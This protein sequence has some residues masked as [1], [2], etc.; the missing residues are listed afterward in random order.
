MSINIRMLQANHGDCFFISHVGGDKVFNIMIDG[1]TKTTFSS[2]IRQRISGPLRKLLNEL[3]QN[4]QCIDLLI[5]THFDDDHIGGLIRGFE[6]QGYLKEMVKKVWFNSSLAITNYFEREEIKENQIPISSGTAETTPK[7]GATL[8]KLLLE[9]G[10]E[11]VPVLT[12]GEET[13]YG[14]FTF[15]ILSPTKDVLE[16]L[17]CIWPKDES[18]AETSGAEN[19]Y[20]LT[21]EDLLNDDDFEEDDSL[22][23]E[24][25]IAFIIEVEDKKL[26]FLGDAH[27]KTI[28]NSLSN[29]G[30]IE[31][32]KLNVDV[33]KISHHASKKNT[34]LE[35]LKI[36]DANN[37]LISS[38]GQKKGA[39]S[40]RTISRIIRSSHKGIVWF[41]YKRVIDNI[42]YSESDKDLYKNRFLE[43]NE[44]SGLEI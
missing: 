3:K 14:P 33:M 44:S 12:A 7:Q 1:G 19:D 42:M 20:H 13:K 43:F 38:N 37:F 2:G 21:F 22:A 18:E 24:S 8:E 27:N 40:K 10:C 29:L 39:A 11:L 30:Y 16:Q 17:L 35:L 41:N 32:T 6:A 36:I 4:N 31:N 34:N 9:I 25:S 26:L 23:N 28:I 15:K 5:L